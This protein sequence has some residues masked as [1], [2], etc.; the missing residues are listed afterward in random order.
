MCLKEIV[1]S[2]LSSIYGTITAIR[3]SIYD[4]EIIKSYKSTLP[5]ISIG[6]ITAGGNAKT[7]LCIAL[8]NELKALGY[9][10]AVLTRGYGGKV[11]G[12][13]LVKDSDNAHKVGDEAL[14]I[15]QK[16][17]LPVIVSPKRS[18]GARFIEEHKLANLIVMDDGFQHRAL[19]RNLNIVSIDVGSEKAVN[20]FLEGKLLPYGRFREDRDLALKRAGIIVFSYRKYLKEIPEID[21]RLLPLIPKG[22]PTFVTS[23]APKTILPLVGEKSFEIGDSV[24]AFCAIAKPERFFDTLEAM[25]VK[26]IAKESFIDHH[27]FTTQDLNNLR[28]KYP[29]VKFVCTEKDAVK[30]S[31]IE[32]ECDLNDF[33][34]LEIETVIHNKEVF[35]KNIQN[36][37][38]Y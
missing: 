5:V 10:P 25:G 13:Y 22:L 12:P 17:A 31:A 2:G 32:N 6:N 8:V 34:K 33:F 30:L 35:M 20:E 3:N 11:K 29:N 18:I 1:L 7:P 37:L 28:E 21:S 26:V 9:N 16:T 4:R 19:F 23:V 38:P 14:L 27:R 24:V 36:Y 15:H